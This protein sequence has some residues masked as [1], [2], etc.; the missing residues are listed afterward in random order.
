[1]EQSKLQDF[2]DTPSRDAFPM[3]SLETYSKILIFPSKLTQNKSSDI[4]IRFSKYIPKYWE[5]SMEI[6]KMYQKLPL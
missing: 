2:T 3:P 6:L 5:I 1:M 4:E